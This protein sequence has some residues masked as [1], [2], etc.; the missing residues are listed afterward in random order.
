MLDRDSLDLV[1]GE[2]IRGLPLCFESIL[3]PSLLIASVSSRLVF[4]VPMPSSA[5]SSALA[6]GNTDL[7]RRGGGGC[8]SSLF[9]ELPVRLRLLPTLALLLF[10]SYAF[11]AL[12]IFA[13]RG[14]GPSR[15]SSCDTG[16]YS[17]TYLEPPFA[18][19]RSS[20]HSTSHP[21]HT[22]PPYFLV[23]SRPSKS[24]HL[25]KRDSQR[26]HTICSPLQ[27]RHVMGFWCWEASDGFFVASPPQQACCGRLKALS[28]ADRRSRI[29]PAD[30]GPNPAARSSVSP[31]A[32]LEHSLPP[33]PPLKQAS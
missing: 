7:R 27:L 29:P 1:F 26:L 3:L 6:C 9:L 4:L 30:P 32:P 18:A 11:R 31:F 13:S 10:C 25:Q 24:H 21:E 20:L 14:E 33:P 22:M 15:R 12:E 19:R 5:S 17:S 8:S 28:N 23:N 16:T 2:S